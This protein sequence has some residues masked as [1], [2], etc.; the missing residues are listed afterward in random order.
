MVNISALIFFSLFF[1]TLTV[2]LIY[3]ISR[4]KEKESEELIFNK[5]YSMNVQNTLRLTDEQNLKPFAPIG[6]LATGS[7][8]PLSLF[9]QLTPPV[10]LHYPCSKSCTVNFKMYEQVEIKLLFEFIKFLMSKISLCGHKFVI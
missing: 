2:S 4:R 7:V 10:Q 5:L 8:D 1:K 9:S 3:F 6:D